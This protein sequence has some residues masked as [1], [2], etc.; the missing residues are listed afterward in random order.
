MFGQD[1]G[2]KVDL[3]R[4][5]RRTITHAWLAN[6]HRPDAG[7]NV[8]R[9]QMTVTHDTRPTVVQA[10][11]HMCVDKTRHLRLNRVGQ[12]PLRPVAKN[13]RQDIAKRPWLNKR[14]HYRIRHGVSFLSWNLWMP[15]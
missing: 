10:L 4:A 9:R 12:Q 2:R 11:A 14:R 7:L 3:C 13:I 1:A 8:A 6:T 15:E 5:I